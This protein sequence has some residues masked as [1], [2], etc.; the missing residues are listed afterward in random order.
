[1]RSVHIDVEDGLLNGSSGVLMGVAKFSKNNSGFD[2]IS[3]KFDDKNIGK[4][5]R[6][7]GNFFYNSKINTAWTPLLKVKRAFMVG[8]YKSVQVI[9]EQVPI[10]TAAAKTC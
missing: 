6:N 3:I 10:R 5:C 9:R 1:M 7:N 8:R 4:Y 2:I